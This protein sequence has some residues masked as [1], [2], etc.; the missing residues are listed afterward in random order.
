VGATLLVSS[1]VICAE[2]ATLGAKRTA[3]KNPA[4]PSSGSIAAGQVTFQK[5][6]RFCHGPDGR[7]HGPI[8]PP[9]TAD[10][11]DA[12][13]DTGSSDIEI[14]TV[15]REGLGPDSKMKGFKGRLTDAEIW[16]IV[17]YIRTLS[18]TKTVAR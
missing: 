8:A 1:I 3:L 15:I 2:S 11:N 18:V 12:H 4:P 6:C 5:N 16:N 17:N 13:W 7:G 9:G 14:F 10:L